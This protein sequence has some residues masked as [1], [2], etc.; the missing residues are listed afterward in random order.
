MKDAF[1]ARHRR[2]YGHGGAVESHLDF[3]ARLS[4]W[5]ERQDPASWNRDPEPVRTT[6][7]PVRRHVFL[8]GY[9]R[10]GVTLVE[11]ILASLPDTRVL[12][13]GATLDAADA[14]FLKDDSTLSRL[15]PLDAGLAD[16]MRAAYWRRVCELVPDV[17]DK[18]FV[19]MS[20][21]Y[22]IKLP[23]IARLFPDAVVV[24]CRRD[25]RDVVLSCF[26][27]HMSPNALTFQL[28]SLEGIARHYDAAMRL[29]ERH[30]AALPLPWHL[31]EYSRLVSDFDATTRELAAF[32]G[33]PWSDRV[34]NFSTTAARMNIRTP[35]ASQV[36]RGLF[37]GTAQWRRYRAQ[38][39]PVLPQ[40]QPWVEKYGYPP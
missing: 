20:P 5:F 39:E 24:L 21:L 40:L 1:V 3:I 31:V 29:T 14:A 15:N 6:V 26:R 27:R 12:E 37:D 34:R 35:S 11:S 22:G 2:R 28:T 30:L 9:L 4:A 38:L 18:V 17:D 7:S 13:E 10:S 33:A 8:L 32:V 36:R 16:A 23:M 19:D 25:P